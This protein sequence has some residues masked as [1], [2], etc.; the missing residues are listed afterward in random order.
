MVSAR[1][2]TNSQY[3]TDGSYGYKGIQTFTINSTTTIIVIVGGNGARGANGHNGAGGYQGEGGAGG[4]SGN[5]NNGNSGTITS[6]VR[7]GEE[8]EPLVSKIFIM[9]REETVVE[10]LME[11]QVV[12]VVTVAQEAHYLEPK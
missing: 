6:G 9:L 3:R 12:E 10:A 1:Q 11:K 4:T 8:G 2:Q 5:G 7:G